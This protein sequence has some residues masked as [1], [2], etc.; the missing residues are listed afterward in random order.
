MTP[1][2]PRS[3]IGILGGGQLGRMLALAAAQL[4]YRVHIFCPEVDSPASQ[5]SAVTTVAAY[6][7]W[8]ALDGFARAV[9]VV[10]LEFENI[11]VAT[12]EYLAALKPAHLSVHPGAKAL[13][14]AQDRV[15]EKDFLNSIGART[16]PYAAVAN[17]AEAEAALA[18]IGYPAV[19]KT[20]RFGYDGKGQSL[21]RS[22]NDL[23][24]AWQSLKSD[25][26]IVEGF[27]PF[28]M[29]ISVLA[30]RSSAGEIATYVPVENRHK[31]HI[32]D[33]S[34]A[35]A[36]ISESLAVAAG[37]LGHKIVEALDYVGILAVEMFVSDD[38]SSGAS[39]LL[40]NEIAPRVHNSGHWTIEASATSQF[41][42][43]IR[44]VCGLPLGSTECYGDAVMTNL[45][46]DDINR[47]REYLAEPGTH[48]HDYGK[49]DAVPGRKMGHITRI[50]PKGHKVLPLS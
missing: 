7:D 36:P 35:P 3:T 50:Y 47:W 41:E 19:L 39:F 21:V 40:V 44:A 10:T 9:D 15:F 46:G 48:F 17:L 25:N 38:T 45:I 11:P 13:G 31:N 32:L 43:H 5:V 34:I 20:R 16:A 4:G 29:E 30:A 33:I 28:K 26:I 12:V 22:R 23:A 1:I 18:R 6:D 8:A 27:V 42:Q 2:P 49:R 24:A 14:V 37:A